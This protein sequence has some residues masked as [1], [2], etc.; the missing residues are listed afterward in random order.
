[1]VAL[2]WYT[3][4]SMLT[5]ARYWIGFFEFDSNIE[6]GFELR[7]L[8]RRLCN[9]TVNKS[10]NPEKA[11]L[12]S[13]K[14]KIECFRL[15]DSDIFMIYV[16]NPSKNLPKSFFNSRVQLSPMKNKSVYFLSNILFVKVEDVFWAFHRRKLTLQ[17]LHSIR[18]HSL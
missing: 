4:K 5:S 11:N 18:N 3:L 1:M 9:A 8:K 15:K 13:N 2:S 16:T 10:G 12:T 17:Q 14:N 7:Q 6:S